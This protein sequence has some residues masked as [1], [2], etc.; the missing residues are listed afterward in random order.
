MSKDKIEWN[1]DYLLKNVESA[2]VGGMK[3]ELTSRNDETRI[4][5]DKNGM[6]IFYTQ[7]R[8]RP[9]QNDAFSQIHCL[10]LKMSGDTKPKVC[11][12]CGCDES[13][14]QIKRCKKC[15]KATYCSRECQQKDWMKHKKTCI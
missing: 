8:F 5:Q 6:H 7:P 2:P 10:Q 9:I 15:K 12:V 13:K 11:V 1:T 14:K 4:T 3:T